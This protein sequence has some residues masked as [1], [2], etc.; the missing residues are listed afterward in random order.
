MT[1]SNLLEFTDLIPTTLTQ[2]LVIPCHAQISLLRWHLESIY[3]PIIMDKEDD[4]S[5]LVRSIHLFKY[6]Y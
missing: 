5:Y 6:Y 4:D 3:G 1:P 2:K